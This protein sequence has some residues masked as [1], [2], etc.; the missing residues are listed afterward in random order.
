[1]NS[2]AQA[3]ILLLLGSVVLR[4]S[5]TDFHLRYVKGGLRPFLIVTGLMLV[6]VALHALFGRRTRS[7]SCGNEGEH[8]AGPGWLLVLPVLAV[9][10]ISPPALGS[11]S[12]QREGTAPVEQAT[13]FPPL[14]DGD[15]AVIPVIDYATRAISGDARLKGRTVKITGFATPGKGGRHYLARIVIACCAADARPIKVALV[16]APSDLKADQWFEVV[17]AFDR[18]VETDS[19]NGEFIASLKVHSMRPVATPAQPYEGR[20]A[21]KR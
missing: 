16:G 6:G 21:P 13:G 15:P 8:G 11:Y 12:A 3:F 1:M 18:T 4:V 9:L 2:R 20:G 17:G 5:L 7:G 19:V 10:L 14:P